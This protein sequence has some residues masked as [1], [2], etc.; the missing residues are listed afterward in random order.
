MRRAAL[1]VL[2]LV[3]L[4]ACRA[5]A[6][7]WGAPAL[8]THPTAASRADLERAVSLA[9]HGMAV[10]LA[11]DALTREDVLIVARAQARDSRGLPL[12]GRVI[13]RPQ[14]FRLLRRR[15]QCVLV[16]VESGKARVL[17]HTT[18][19]MLPASRLTPKADILRHGSH[20]S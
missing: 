12:N 4:P 3:T 7:P 14:H 20:L 6:Q 19:R 15:S 9:L 17:E 13:E 18:C 5:G 1:L 8:I 2:A 16:H 10:R 11:D